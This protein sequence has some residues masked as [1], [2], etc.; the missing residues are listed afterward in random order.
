MGYNGEMEKW[1]E[2]FAQ[3]M[4]K[5]GL[6]EGFLEPK[7]EDLSDSF[8]LPGMEKA[9]ER[10]LQTS[11]RD[12][13][14]VVYGDYDVDGVC[15]SVVMK[16]ALE[17]AGVR[18]VEIMLPDRFIDGYG[19]NEGAVA[20]IVEAGAGLVVTVDCG[21]GSGEVISALKKKKVDCI[22]TDHH[23]IP[24]VPK[25]AVVVVNPKLG[26]VGRDLSGSGVAFAVARAINMR[27]NGGVFDGQEKWLLDL[28]AIGTV[29]DVMDLTGENRI[30]VKFGMTVLKKTRREGLLALM[31]VAKVRERDIDAHAIGFQI[32]PRLNAGGR[33]QTARKALR[34]LLAEGRAEAFALA[35]ELEDLNKERRIVQGKALCE[36]EEGG[37]LT[38]EPVL[39]ARGDWHEGVVGIVAGRLMDKYKRPTFVFTNVGDGL[40]KGSGRSFGEFAL[41]D[42][43][44]H[45][46]KM[47][48][49]GG[50][51]NFAC[52]VTIANSDFEAF[53]ECVNEYYRGLRLKNQERFLEVVEDVVVENVGDLTK[54]LCWELSL[55]EPYGEGNP[56]PVFKLTGVEVLSAKRMGAE[57]KHLRLN[58]KGKDG[59]SVKLVAFFAPDEWLEVRE[60]ERLDVLVNLRINEYNGIRTV[61]GRILGVERVGEI[62]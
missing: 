53:T 41:A 27:T 61:E 42:C 23:E 5:R 32:G 39:V 55:L 49:A 26:E 45:C 24:E 21:S 51:H 35:D 6:D 57:G 52:G 18:E 62:W 33:M 4:R 8:L 56:E 20:K 36:I 54:S 11:E 44:I 7:Y 1:S 48:V 15:A 34:L 16:E 31:R 17:L 14:V 22:V 37:G 2:L 25:D 9:V 43:I 58:V 46:Q 12:E 3:L 13:K 28:V 19:M 40:L 60:G 29:C 38:D 59:R 30:L 47:L 50:G 10:I